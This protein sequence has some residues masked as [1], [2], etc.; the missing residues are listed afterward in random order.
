MALNKNGLKVNLRALYNDTL[1]N[2][3]LS[4]EGAKE[5]FINGLANAIETFIKTATVNYIT[6]LT[7]ASGGVVTGTFNHTIS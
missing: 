6:G 2:K 3:G 4:P 7:S 1:D 5:A